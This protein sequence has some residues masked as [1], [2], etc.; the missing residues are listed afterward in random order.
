MNVT[1][2][3]TK[4]SFTSPASLSASGGFE[5]TCRRNRILFGYRFVRRS[6][7]CP[8]G[9][10]LST[11]YK[12]AFQ[13]VINPK[14]GIV[15]FCTVST[16]ECSFL[17]QQYCRRLWIEHEFSLFP[18]EMQAWVI[19]LAHRHFQGESLGNLHILGTEEAWSAVTGEVYE[20]VKAQAPSQ[21]S[22]PLLLC[23]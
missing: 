13:A 23:G 16:Q 1:A 10:P 14:D 20:P 5:T 8:R 19:D 12:V 3:S 2:F 18:P 17:G 22:P 4:G 7:S 15:K 11:I 21:V 6:F 9:I